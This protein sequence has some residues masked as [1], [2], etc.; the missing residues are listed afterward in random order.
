[1]RIGVPKEIKQQEHRI[2]LTP[3]SVKALTSKGHKV[4]VEN[5]GGFE[6]GFSNDDYKNAGAVIE[7]KASEIF[8]NSDLIVKV[9]E[10]QKK[11]VDMIRENQINEFNIF[12]ISNTNSNELLEEVIDYKKIIGNFDKKSQTVQN[13]VFP[14]ED[15]IDYVEPSDKIVSSE[16]GINQIKEELDEIKKD[17]NKGI[18]QTNDITENE[19]TS[20]TNNTIID[21]D[22][23]TNEALDDNLNINLD[24]EINVSKNIE[25]QNNQTSKRKDKRKK[26]GFNIF[27][28][29]QDFDRKAY[30]SALE[31]YLNLVYSGKENYEIL[32]Y[33]SNSYFNNSQYDKAVIW[34]NKLI[35]KY[36]KNTTNVFK[37]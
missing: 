9:K 5:N 29:L 7:N 32:N 18:A 12:K 16:G 17:N 15:L 11:E 4:L 19:K 27:S 35:S 31:K 20:F 3:E 8:K 2:G 37:S 36:P 10:P 1:M 14:D 34:F 28:A 6:A 13:I 26:S 24:E 21:T 30:N 23:K 22:N 33:I 25:I